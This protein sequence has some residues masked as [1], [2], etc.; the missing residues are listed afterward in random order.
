MATVTPNF[1]WP[2][3]TSTDLVK[4]GATAIEALGDSIDASL[5]DLKGGTSGQVLSKNSNT[6]MDFV[7]VTD[8]AGDITGVTAGTGITG[9]GTSGTVTVSFDQANFGGGQF[10]AGKNKIINGDFNINQ[11]AFTSTTTNNAYTFDRWIAGIVPGTGVGTFS[12]QTFTPGSAPVVGYESTNYLRIVTTGIVAGG[13]TTSQVRAGQRIEDVRT[14]ADQTMTVSF[15]AKSGSGTPNIGVRVDQNFGS[16]GSASTDTIAGSV[17]AITSSWVRYSFTVAVPSV[18]G[19]TI[20]AGSFLDIRIFVV[21]GS[22]IADV[23]GVGL[24]DNT[25]E[26]WGVQV[27]AGNQ[28]TPFQTATGTIQGELAA[29]QRYY[30]KVTNA[31]GVGST[32]TTGKCLFLIPF[33]VEMRIAPTATYSAGSTFYIDAGGA[34]TATA[35][36]T[37]VSRTFQLAVDLDRTGLTQYQ[38][39][40]V[41][42]NGTSTIEMSSEL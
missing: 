11:R 19:K 26:F 5:V 39:A 7:W 17:T 13:T 35:V 14:F 34:G 30:Q 42:N 20:G 3:P 1:N 9:G 4:D 33:P 12:A 28:M 22:A 25:F 21:A 36:A 24:Q 23:S 10:A 32:R 16:G 31:Y 15:Y 27:E 6:D 29:C 2:V 37:N 18:S 41:S 40:V 8:A 38:A